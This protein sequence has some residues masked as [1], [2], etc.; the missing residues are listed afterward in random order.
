MNVAKETYLFQS[1]VFSLK[2]RFKALSDRSI[3]PNVCGCLRLACSRRISSIFVSSCINSETNA[4]PR[5]ERVFEG[6]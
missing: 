1:F 2:M 4:V 3:T 5:S 6:I